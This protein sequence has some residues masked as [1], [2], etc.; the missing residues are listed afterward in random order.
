[1]KNKPKLLFSLIL[2]G[3]ICAGAAELEINLA[4]NP[5]FLPGLDKQGPTGW[6]Y[7][8]GATGIVHAGRGYVEFF[9]D[10][11][12]ITGPASL[13]QFDMW[14]DMTPQYK[15][16]CRLKSVG[17]RGGVYMELR[18]RVT[19]NRQ[20]HE[21]VNRKLDE[22]EELSMTVGKGKHYGFGLGIHVP[23]DA[24]LS[25]SRLRVTP[26]LAPATNL[27]ATL[28]V[29][30]KGESVR[31]RGIITSENPRWPEIMAAH[32]LRLDA[33]LTT[34]V[35][36]PVLAVAPAEQAKGYIRLLDS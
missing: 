16:S 1:M 23:K 14:D 12:T 26:I 21:L 25:I 29:A 2:S 36:L 22:W 27:E 20:R 34:G 11:M 19:G 17:V 13:H 10:V 8:G 6:I 18:D 31:A 3:C 30:D 35:V 33:W 24:A 5:D 9:T 7:Y 32:E 28:L 4:R 15:F